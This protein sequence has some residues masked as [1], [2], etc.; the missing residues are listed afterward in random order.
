MY[1]SETLFTFFGVCHVG[2]NVLKHTHKK[3]L[4]SCIKYTEG[5]SLVVND[6]VIV[7]ITII[8]TVIITSQLW[9]TLCYNVRLSAYIH[10]FKINCTKIIMLYWGKWYFCNTP[11]DVL[12]LW[13][14]PRLDSRNPVTISTDMSYKSTLPEY[15]LIFFSYFIL[16]GSG[17][18]WWL[19]CNTNANTAMKPEPN[20]RKIQTSA[21]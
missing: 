8:I 9:P 3:W 11:S 7:F 16:L 15:C 12:Q 18:Y 1:S 20:H 6:I 14:A 2:L 13:G 5:V 4:E 21:D 10:M 17:Y 19:W